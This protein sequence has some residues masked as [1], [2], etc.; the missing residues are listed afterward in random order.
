MIDKWDISKW[1]QESLKWFIEIYPKIPEVSQYM[2]YVRGSLPF[3]EGF[4]TLMQ[5]GIRGDQIG[6]YRGTAQQSLFHFLRQQREGQKKSAP[7]PPILSVLLFV[8]FL[9]LGK[10]AAFLPFSTPLV[11]II[12]YIPQLFSKPACS[13]SFL[14]SSTQH[15][16]EHYSSFRIYIL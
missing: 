1:Y 8:C 14:S 4:F 3:S 12:C 2:G 13:L 5:Q 6:R 10:T 15:E 16:G 11:T 9:F 7:P